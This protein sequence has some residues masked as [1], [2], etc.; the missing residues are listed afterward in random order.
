MPSKLLESI[1]SL[2][3]LA[4]AERQLIVK[5]FLNGKSLGKQTPDKNRVSKN[6]KHPPFTF[7]IK[8]FVKGKLEA[9]G[10]ID[11]KLKCADVKLT[12]EKASKINVIVDNDYKELQESDEDIFFVKAYVV[13]KNNTLIS[14][15]KGKAKFNVKGSGVLI[16]E[17][18]VAFEAGVAS[19]VLKANTKLKNVEISATSAEL[20]N[21][22]N[23]NKK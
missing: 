4:M 23:D 5:L 16:G 6:L 1:P 11:N 18:P 15:F 10:Y 22:S 20:K 17:N 3:S 9:I 12:P 21:N 19:I 7:K 8:S 13:D 14:D 2:I